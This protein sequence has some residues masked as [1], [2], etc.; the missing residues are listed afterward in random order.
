M[1]ACRQ[2]TPAF[3]NI[4]RY[5]NLHIWCNDSAPF[6]IRN[7]TKHTTKKRHQKTQLLKWYNFMVS[8]CIQH[9]RTGENRGKVFSIGIDL[10]LGKKSS[11]W[12][13][14]SVWLCW[15]L[16]MFSFFFFFFSSVRLSSFFPP[17]LEDAS[18]SRAITPL[19]QEADSKLVVL[20]NQNIHLQLVLC[21]VTEVYF[22]QCGSWC[23]LYY[24]GV[25]GT[26]NC[27]VFFF[28]V[29]IFIA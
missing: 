22:A 23:L 7:K 20:R 8:W 26:W 24:L 19:T 6:G 16:C 4:A 17:A 9:L 1:R 29:F 12:I 27:C 18:L 21:W 28:I 13:M 25:V 14:G 15:P 10:F 2:D 5:V 11:L 3:E